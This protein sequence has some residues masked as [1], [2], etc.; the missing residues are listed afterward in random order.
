MIGT[1]MTSLDDRIRDLV[2]QGKQRAE[3]ISILGIGKSSLY[4]RLNKLGLTREQLSHAAAIP[5]RVREPHLMTTEAQ[6][7]RLLSQ[8]AQGHNAT[9]PAERNSAFAWARSLIEDDMDITYDDQW[10]EIPADK[11]NWH[12]KRVYDAAVQ[13]RK[14][15]GSTQP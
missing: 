12:I 13:G 2:E 8:S 6:Y 9:T 14:R 7:L 10:R 5:W 11:N 1:A 4:R 15:S 3:I